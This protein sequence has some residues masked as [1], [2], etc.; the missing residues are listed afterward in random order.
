[1]QKWARRERPIREYCV[2]RLSL[3]GEFPGG[4]VIGLNIFTAE[5]PGSIPGWGTQILQAA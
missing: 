2:Q 4:P 5:G 3:P 1:M